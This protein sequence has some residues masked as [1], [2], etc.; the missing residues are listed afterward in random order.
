MILRGSRGSQPCVGVGELRQCGAAVGCGVGHP[1]EV[2]IEGLE[3]EIAGGRGGCSRRC[4]ECK[5]VGRDQGTWHSGGSGDA[6]DR[7]GGGCAAEDAPCSP[8]ARC[9]RLSMS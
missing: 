2:T 4:V 8:V 7:D 1:V 6:V 5:R 9:S 3:G